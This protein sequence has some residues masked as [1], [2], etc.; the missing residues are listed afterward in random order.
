MPADFTKTF[1]RNATEA[2]KKLWRALRARQAGAAKFC[3]QHRIGRYIVD[4]V[5]LEI[6][7]VI[8]VDGGQHATADECERD[9]FLVAEGYRVLRIWN[10]EVLENLDGV[11]ARIVES[12]PLP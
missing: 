12:F 2:E 3:R 6:G 10:N 9:A 4:F 11:L 7:L 5:A 1:R 8:E